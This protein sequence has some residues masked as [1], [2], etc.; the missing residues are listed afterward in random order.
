M[1]APANPQIPHD[2][3]WITHRDASGQRD[4]VIVV[5]RASWKRQSVGVDTSDLATWQTLYSDAS[6]RPASDPLVQAHWAERATRV[7]R[8]LMEDSE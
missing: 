5:P 4:G 1:E 8:D 7:K 2:E 3:I 6:F